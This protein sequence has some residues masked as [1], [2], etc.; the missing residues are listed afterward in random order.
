MGV[1]VATPTRQVRHRD[2]IQRE[3]FVATQHPRLGSRT[4]W[5]D[6]ICDKGYLHCHQPLVAPQ[7]TLHHIV[8]D[9]YIDQ[10]TIA[11]HGHHLRLDHRTHEVGTQ[12]IPLLAVDRP[13]NVSI[14][15]A[16]LL[17]RWAKNHT[18]R[19]S[20]RGHLHIAP[21]VRYARIDEEG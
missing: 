1:E 21:V 12:H 10:L 11:L 16:H 6:T 3:Q 13:Y 15:E 8:R 4:A 14:V 9:R 19:D 2:A 18:R 7:D 5:H 17:S 20:S